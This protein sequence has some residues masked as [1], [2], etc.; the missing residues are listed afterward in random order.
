MQITLL[1]AELISNF[2]WI[3][4]EKSNLFE[5]GKYETA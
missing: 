4:S 5:A 1:D 2:V 3:S